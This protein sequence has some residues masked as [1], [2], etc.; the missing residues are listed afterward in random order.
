MQ[1]GVLGRL[2]DLRAAPGRVAYVLEGVLPRNPPFVGPPFFVL[3]WLEL[4]LTASI[5]VG[6]F[7]SKR[8]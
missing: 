5:M 3:G 7:L 8:R 6:F 1:Q 2:Q 4:C